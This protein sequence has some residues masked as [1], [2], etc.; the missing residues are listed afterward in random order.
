MTECACCSAKPILLYSRSGAVNTG[1]LADRVTR[2]LAREGFGSMTCLAAVGAQLSGF[3]E[4]ATSALFNV[5]I[6]GCPVACGKK[7]FETNG[8]PYLEVKTTEF[9]VIKGKTPITEELVQKVTQEIKRK[10]ADQTCGSSC[11]PE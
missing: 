5:I 9:D 11:K 4:S 3:I 7:I 6:D 1:W 10:L 8:L 2:E